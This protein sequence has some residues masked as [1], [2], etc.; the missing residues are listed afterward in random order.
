MAKPGAVRGQKGGGC[1]FQ[2][3]TP[4]QRVS[5]PPPPPPGP[6][7]P[8]CCPQW[9]PYIRLIAGQA[10]Y[11][12]WGPPPARGT[13]QLGRSE[14]LISGLPSSVI[15]FVGGNGADR[16]T[17]RFANSF[18]LFD[19]VCILIP[20]ERGGGFEASFFGV[21]WG[22]WFLLRSNILQMIWLC[23]AWQ[24]SFPE[25]MLDREGEPFTFQGRGFT[26]RRKWEEGSIGGWEYSCC[27]TPSCQYMKTIAYEYS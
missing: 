4:T 11:R 27:N 6:Q 23:K 5:T 24:I 1:S 9:P 12:T 3:G 17:D 20:G 7:S 16:E 21:K 14:D 18:Q 13:S 26:A 8:P 2:I 15:G 10:Y 19:L 22:H 25:N